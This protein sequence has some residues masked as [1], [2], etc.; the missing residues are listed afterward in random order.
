MKKIFIPI[1][2]LV[3]MTLIISLVSAGTLTTTGNSYLL[4]SAGNPNTIIEKGSNYYYATTVGAV[5]RTDSVF[6]A[7]T[8]VYSTAG[9]TTIAPTSV[10]TSLAVGLL[11][12]SG[13]TQIK[14]GNYGAGTAT[15]NINDYTPLANP[16]TSIVDIDVLN[17]NNDFAILDSNNQIYFFTLIEDTVGVDFL[18]DNVI[19]LSNSPNLTN[20]YMTRTSDRIYIKTGDNNIHSYNLAGDLID[21][22]NYTMLDAND[23]MISNNYMYIIDDNNNRL[24]EHTINE[25]GVTGDYFPLEGNLYSY[26]LCITN[27][28]LC[29]N[30]SYITDI[31]GNN[32][33]ICNDTNDITYCSGGCQNIENEQGIIEGVCTQYGCENECQ[34]NGFQTCMT[35]STYSI[36]GQFDQD[37]C[38]EYGSV[39]QCPANQFCS[40]DNLGGYCSDLE[41]YTDYNQNSL[42]VSI[43][44][45]NNTGLLNNKGTTQI[46]NNKVVDKVLQFI[47]PFNYGLLKT[48]KTV[49]VSTALNYMNVNF[50]TTV[51][52]SIQGSQDFIGVDCDYEEIVLHSDD[53]SHFDLDSY[54]W[55]YT[56]AEIKTDVEGYQYVKIKDNPATKNFN[57]GSNQKLELIVR[58]QPN[59]NKVYPIEFYSNTVLLN[60]LS[61]ENNKDTHTLTIRDVTSNKI[62]A[63]STSS[64]E[65]F[66]H[67]YLGLNYIDDIKTVY[68]EVSIIRDVSGQIINENF[69]SLPIATASTLQVNKAT[70]LNTGKEF[71]VY[72]INGAHV[73]DYPIYK[74]DD[75]TQ[76]SFTC[77]Y[78]Q[79]GCYDIKVYG[80][81]QGIPTYHFSDDYRVCISKLGDQYF[82][83]TPTVYGDDQVS[84]LEKI[85]GTTWDSKTKLLVAISIVLVVFIAFLVLGTM[86]GLPLVSIIGTVVAGLLLIYFAIEGYIPAWTIVLLGIIGAF[87]GIAIFRNGLLGKN[88][89]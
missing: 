75:N 62:I 56:T 49:D 84:T 28:K 69:Y 25:T 38:L 87:I 41:P 17:D 2:F 53:L 51:Y 36:C 73:D 86:N 55:V 59:E 31:L 33:F 64:A 13:T 47:S 7:Q 42:L 82:F 67:I 19:S 23:I 43:T 6:G 3:L 34:I 71:W 4:D 46:V 5:V 1:L 83:Q 65:N 79:V 10:D 61:I 77:S 78:N 70:F 76:K 26:E 27:T 88:G 63:Q 35:S 21:T 32:Y 9:L 8:V 22:Y 45:E 29:S 12:R 80:N 30:T 15:Y 48:V 11:S 89:G 74:Y 18:Y 20:A 81:E 50:D 52:N 57:S 24:Y 39:L 16:I 14:I 44:H 54:G 60:K 58:P 85:F 68:I 37:A 72:Q 40:Q 66:K